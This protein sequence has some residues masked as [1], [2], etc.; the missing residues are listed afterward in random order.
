MERI[1]KQQKI[2]TQKNLKLE[3]INMSNRFEHK[4][5]TNIV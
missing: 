2:L 4:A 5:I 1:S 3:N